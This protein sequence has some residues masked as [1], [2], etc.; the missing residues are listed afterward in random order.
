MRA[1]GALAAGVLIAAAFPPLGLSLSVVIGVALLLAMVKGVLPGR[2]FALG[3]CTG[4]A[5]FAAAINWVVPTISRFTGAATT[6]AFLIFVVFVA[7]HA[8]QLGAFAAVVANQDGGKRPAVDCAA[9]AAVWVVIEWGFPHVFPWALGDALVESSLLRQ[10]ADFAGVHG[11]SFLIVFAGAAFAHAAS[12]RRLATAFLGISVLGVMSS[13]G[14]LR[15]AMERDD[16]GRPGGV[17]VAAIQGGIGVF[18][19][20]AQQNEQAWKTYERM[21]LEVA[22]RGPSVHRSDGALT[23][24]PETTLRTYLRHDRR[25]LLQLQK[26]AARTHRALLVGALD[27][28]PSGGGE[29]NSAFLVLP[30]E[31]GRGTVVQAYDKRILVPFGEYVPGAQLIS[32]LLGWIPPGGFVSGGYGGPLEMANGTRL[33]LSICFEVLHPGALNRIVRDGAGLLVNL[34]DDSWFGGAV[35]PRQHLGGAVMRAVETRRWL[36]RVSDSG[37][38]AIIDPTGRIVDHLSVGA[39]G[40]LKAFVP[41][42]DTLSPYV[43]F[44]DW[45]VPVCCL[46]AVARFFP[47]TSAWRR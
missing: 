4:A 23:V 24:W 12:R 5:G 14:A 7:Y 17:D 43:R 20:R 32:F 36:V 26:L 11:L 2:A 29:L 40:A 15:L 16:D 33:G 8:L 35:E 42:R 22:G 18:G 34:S 25:R 27:L 41:E 44:G 13:Y 31:E 9:A 21:T 47:S 28:P 38:S 39:V 3:C 19:D 6:T 46:L 1:L 45:L 10:S 30:A 37:I